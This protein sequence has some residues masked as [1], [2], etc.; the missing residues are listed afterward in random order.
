MLFFLSQDELTKCTKKMEELI[1][2]MLTENHH[3]LQEA[4]EEDSK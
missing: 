2:Q 1:N 3:L 4:K